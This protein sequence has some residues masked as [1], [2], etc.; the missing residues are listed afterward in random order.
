MPVPTVWR[1]QLARDFADT[2]SSG[3]EGTDGAAGADGETGADGEPAVVRARR[4]M[5]RD[6]WN[7]LCVPVGQGGM[8]LGW[9]EAGLL[10]AELG[11]ALQPGDVLDTVLAA[12]WF[13]TT[14]PESLKPLL[15]GE[16]TAGIPVSPRSTGRGVAC[17][18]ERLPDVVLLAGPPDGPADGPAHGPAD[19][20]ADGPPDGPPTGVR[21]LPTE[22]LWAKARTTPGGRMVEVRLRADP[23]QGPWLPAG[24]LWAAAALLRSAYLLGLGRTAVRSAVDRAGQ[25]RQF[26]KLIGTYQA[27]GFPLA[28][29]RAR[30]EGLRLEVHAQLLRLDS[31]ATGA[32]GTTAARTADVQAAADALQ[33]AVRP[34]VREC[35]DHALHVSGASGLAGRALSAR[36]YQRLLVEE[37][38]GGPVS[39]AGHGPV[40][41]SA[42]T[43]AEPRSLWEPGPATDG[44]VALQQHRELLDKR[45]PAAVN[46]TAASY[47]QGD[48]LHHLFER[49]AARHPDR[50]A[51]RSASTV[52]T[53]RELEARAN[54]LAHVLR[55]HGT[56][57][58]GTG[59][60]SPVAICMERGPDAIVATLAVL[61]ASGACLFLDPEHPPERSAFVL[62]DSGAVA[63]LTQEGLRARLGEVSVPVLP[64]D[65]LRPLVDRQ[66]S[67][68]LPPRAG[69]RDL[70]YLVYTSG[71]TGTPKGV[72]VEHRNLVNRM[73]WD[74]GTFPLGPRDA[75][76]Q[77]TALGFDASIWEIFA[78]LMS[79]ASLVLAPP[80]AAADPRALL[81][82]MVETGV[83]AFTCV[84]SV[85]DLLLD[86]K[87]P[88]LA[89]VRGLR[90]IFCGG[91]TLPPSLVGRLHRSGTHAVLHNLYGPTECA[92][93]VTH[94]RCGPRDA[95]AAVP[96]GRPLGNV[97]IHVLDE[98]GAPVPVGFQGELYVAGA[99][100][101]RGYRHRPALTAERFLPDPFTAEPGARMYRTGDMVR[102][103]PDGA[104]D[105]LGRH[106]DQVKVRGHRIELG[107]IR[108]ALERR[109]EVRRAV[110]RA[111]AG[112]IDAYV[113]PAGADAPDA[114]LLRDQLRRTLPHY[115]VPTGIAFLTA[116]PLTPNGKVD[117]EALPT[118]PRYP[119]DGSHGHED[120]DRTG[121]LFA[122]EGEL[123]LLAARVLG[124]EHVG[125]AEDFFA[126]GGSS[127][128]AARYV[129]RVRD[130][131]GV[132]VDLETFLAA[133]TVEGLAQAL[134]DGGGGHADGGD[135]PER[136]RRA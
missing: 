68:R 123:A 94:W 71:S 49:A 42:A 100:V 103:R 24:P 69:P 112:R 84:P 85:L 92:I 90:H 114:G 134:G 74:A 18:T 47:P 66:P 35:V 79:G 99:G 61:K 41:W 14:L 32:T 56:G 87:E 53:Y 110:V 40:E 102:L 51:L 4:V 89:D 22:E 21:A 130:E 63:V 113:V 25:R 62:R 80:R 43:S 109:P 29:Q 111:A 116:V 58:N 2:W 57:A 108:D 16:L 93:D 39:A 124:V 77:Q 1:Q 78:P 38:R 50:T 121:Q 106:D 83:T 13:A 55:A 104:L 133:P 12:P 34:L 36:C 96:I 72:E 131:L 98:A 45:V 107:E 128:H 44:A 127:L 76:L 6:G 54:R 73:H 120:G 101:A 97:R 82:T 125:P 95:R 105:F 70:A 122:L 48:G 8:G 118:P 91:E 65:G 115:M 52:L 30:L 46:D 135:G 9:Y 7:G 10:A 20:P 19:G 5:A 15:E 28:A 33:E 88:G 86:E 17:F 126:A 129:T 81:E 117:H 59:A 11:R 119:G 26:G 60:N 136:G 3:A 75:V 37:A 27:V 64:V 67:D 31:V 132:R 23:P